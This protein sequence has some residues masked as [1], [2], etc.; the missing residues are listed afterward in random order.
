M[1]CDFFGVR[2]YE[3]LQFWKSNMHASSNQGFRLFGQVL[4]SSS[5]DLKKKNQKTAIPRRE[6]AKLHSVSV[7]ALLPTD[8]AWISQPTEL[9]GKAKQYILQEAGFFS[10]LSGFHL[11][12]E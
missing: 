1:I 8:S 5:D 2:F 9:F 3:R 4:P 7:R 12:L 6:L 10:H 11:G